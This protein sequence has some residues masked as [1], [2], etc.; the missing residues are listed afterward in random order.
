M[1]AES[2]REFPATTPSVIAATSVHSSLLS[3][4]EQLISSSS[5]SSGEQLTSS[6]SFSSSA[7]DPCSSSS[8]EDPSFSSSAGDAPSAPS[9][10]L[11]SASSPRLV[12]EYSD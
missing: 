8:A 9:S 1:I 6:F 3:S 2:S 5:F 11:E 10:P 7:E 12:I 4:D